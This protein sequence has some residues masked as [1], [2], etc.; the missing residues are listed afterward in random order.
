M[1]ILKRKRLSNSSLSVLLIKKNC[2][3]CHLIYLSLVQCHVTYMGFIP[4]L[5]SLYEVMKVCMIHTSLYLVTSIVRL[6][7]FF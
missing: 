4:S 7:I 3:V 6:L 1:K 2:V 5:L